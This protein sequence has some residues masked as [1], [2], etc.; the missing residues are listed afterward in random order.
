MPSALPPQFPSSPVPPHF[1]FSF[2]FK[3]YLLFC[4]CSV[5]QSCPTLC[6]PMDYNMP[7][8]PV[9]HQL[10]E[11][12]QIHVRRVGDAIQPS[13]LLS[14]SSSPAF[15]LSQHQGLFQWVSSSHKVAK[16]LEFQLQHQS[17][18]WIFRT[19]FP[20]RLT[21]WI[22]FQSMVLIFTTD[23]LL[24]L[25]VLPAEW[26]L[27]SLSFNFIIPHMLQAVIAFHT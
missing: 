9:H 27:I 26:C 18:Q 20:L 19:D 15:N 16:I 11:F 14:S 7:G 22:S 21:D 24:I 8:F 10:L 23:K 17:F 5:A 12:T 4:C 6:D 25:F 3:S 1:Q 2:L 13:Y